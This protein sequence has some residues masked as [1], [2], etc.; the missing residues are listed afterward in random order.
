MVLKGYVQP[1]LSASPS[2]RALIMA[3]KRS[4]TSLKPGA[5]IPNGLDGI[6]RAWLRTS[7]YFDPLIA[8]TAEHNN[9]D[10]LVRRLIWDDAVLVGNLSGELLLR[11]DTLCLAVPGD[12]QSHQHG[13]NEAEEE[14]EK[15]GVND[16]IPRNKVRCSDLKRCAET[17]P[18]GDG[19]LI[20][21]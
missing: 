8:S 14:E 13:V 15:W 18:G 7:R 20:S 3:S 17:Q 1:N 12:T 11:D 10:W 5:S 16:P 4:T 21:D 2:S 9:R 19:K 6:V